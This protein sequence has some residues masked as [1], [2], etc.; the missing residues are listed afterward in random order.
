MSSD[1]SIGYVAIFK[2]GHDESRHK[3]TLLS[4]Q[5]LIQNYNVDRPKIER[6]LREK[7]PYRSK[8]VS[9]S[10]PQILS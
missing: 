1:L 4:G 6:M 9:G 3:Q 8:F 5:S 2:P 7:R 10:L